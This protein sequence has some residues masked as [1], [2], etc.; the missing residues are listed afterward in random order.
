MCLA[1][2]ARKARWPPRDAGAGQVITLIVAVAILLVSTAYVFE[3][4]LHVPQ[5][6]SQSLAQ[7]DLAHAAQGAL[8]V[9]LGTPGYPVLWGSSASSI[10]GVSRLGLITPDSTARIDPAKL[11]ALVRGHYNG[12]STTNGFVDYPEARTAL[13]LEGY[14]YHFRTGP[15]V[16]AA[17]GSFGLTGMTSY[18]VAYVGNA[19]LTHANEATSERAQLDALA[20]SFRDAT[21]LTM[22]GDGDAYPDDV[23]Q[24]RA[25]LLPALGGRVTET[26]LGAGVG[27]ATDFRVVPAS[28]YTALVPLQ[29]FPSQALALADAS[30][31][32]GYAPARELR[33]VIGPIDLSSAIVSAAVSWNERVDTSLDAND[34]G[35]VEAS[36]DN[37]ATW[38][39]LTDDPTQRSTDPGP[40]SLTMT[41]RTANL[42]VGCGACLG[43]SSVL[44]A[45]HWIADGNAVT[46]GGWVIDD[47]KV[48]GTTGNVLAWRTFDAPAYDAIVIGSD[49]DQAI[50]AANDVKSALADFV[51]LTG[52]RIL[53]LGGQQSAAWLPPAFHLAARD[54]NAALGNPDVTHPILNVPNTLDWRSYATTGSWDFSA[55]A[56]APLFAGVLASSTDHD[57]LALSTLGAFGRAHDGGIIL[58][59]FKPATMT[60]D[61]GERFFAN[62][63][64]YGRYQGLYGDIGPALPPD[65]PVSSASRAALVDASG[66][67]DYKQISVTIY[68][69]GGMTN[70]TSVTGAP[71]GSTPTA[72]RDLTAGSTAPVLLT[73]NVP[74]S[75]GAAALTNYSI[76]RGN[77]LGAE[78]L[79]ATIGTNRSFADAT[80]QV[81]HTYFYNVTAINANGPSSSTPDVQ[82]TPLTTPDAPGGLTA[83]PGLEQ[84][85]LAWSAPAAGST[86]GSAVTGYQ[87]YRGATSGA[88]ALLTTIGSNTTFVDAG[89]PSG[90]TRYYTVAAVAGGGVSTQSGEAYATTLSVPFSPGAPVVTPGLRE[91]LITWTPPADGGL[92]ITG[93]N[94]YASSTSGAETLLVRVGASTLDYTDTGLAD[95]QTRYYEV[96]AN[97][98]RG[99]GTRSPEGSGTTFTIAAPPTLLTATGGIGNIG[100]SW[101]APLTDGGSPV[102]GYK[103]YAGALAGT[104]TILSTIG[105]NTTYVDEG[106]AAGQTR[107]YKVTAQNA[108]GE[109]LASNEA[110]ATTIGVPTAPLLPIATGGTN[111]ISLSWTAPASNGGAAITGYKIYRGNTSGSETLLATIGTNTS[112]LDASLSTNQ[113]RYYKIA[114]VSAAGT[115]D[116]STEASATTNGVPWAPLALIA[117]PGNGVG[118]G[119]GHISL[120][121]TAPAYDGGSVVT[122]YSIYRGTSLGGEGTT[123]IETTTSN[124][125]DDKDLQSGTLYYYVVKA[126][127]SAGQS[128][129]S[130]E[131]F[132]IAHP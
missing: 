125:Y 56:E 100:L 29:P 60:T 89:L 7:H 68:V 6:A 86:G 48:T 116:L 43:S 42:A 10:D 87:I 97:N 112:F 63:L 9:L 1:S 102:T 20:I 93:Y 46:G 126:T 34:H 21:P 95:G 110:T 26:I 82:A 40:L 57:Q 49:A 94:L 109:S 30:S 106:L 32:I 101:N 124:S 103:I 8:N 62:T 15:L 13:G 31:T 5:S 121:W 58:T 25:L 88:E 99:E 3:F 132:T 16:D 24:L 54:A 50:L 130:N 70:G 22:G 47:V 81:G 127:N 131:A 59:T 12:A 52:G 17:I 105:T 55:S 36:P 108:A 80:A 120:N 27:T 104:E 114:A 69:W 71:P 107:F 85:S 38:Y 123:A 4:T 75:L 84:I 117:T 18:R 74:D 128:P 76:Y 66:Q 14:D 98:S 90:A 83:L 79:L 44:L 65:V 115:G 53:V 122:L 19:S 11:D 67:G 91:L 73:W 129:A 28:A 41:A 61:D 64:L 119:N 39:A 118:I 96:S 35:F 92:D 45:F 33:A 111:N 37:G 2:T 78:T 77:A 72:P 113:T 23:T 51:N